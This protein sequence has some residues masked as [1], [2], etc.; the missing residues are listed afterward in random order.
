LRTFE[1]VSAVKILDGASGEIRVHAPLLEL[2]GDSPGSDSGRRPTSRPGRGEAFVVDQS[3]F[4]QP[5]H[6]G[7]AN[8]MGIAVVGEPS[9]YFA[10]RTIAIAEKAQGALFSMP[11]LRVAEKGFKFVVGVRCAFLKGKLLHH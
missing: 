2:G 7:V 6:H 3:Q 9:V 11:M 8:G 1:L 4:N 10:V 5:T